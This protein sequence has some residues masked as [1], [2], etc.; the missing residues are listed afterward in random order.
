[1]EEL[2]IFDIG[3][4][5]VITE[6]EKKKEE[7][8]KNSIAARAKAA[9]TP[10][11]KK[12]V[13]PI[14]VQ[15]DWTIHFATESFR[16]EDFVDEIP[17][18]G[19]TLEEVR[20]GI[21]RHF[22]QFSAART[23]WDV[24]KDN[25]RLF[26]DAFAGSKGAVS[27]EGRFTPSFFISA[28]E[29]FESNKIYR[30]ILSGDGNVLSV[31]QS[32]YG[33]MIAPTIKVSDKMVEKALDDLGFPSLEACPV[34]PA[35]FEWILP[36]IPNKFLRQIVG[37]FRSFITEEHEYEVAVKI[38]FD[39]EKEKYVLDVPEQIV[40][41]VYISMINTPEYTGQNASR[42]LP[43]MEVHSHNVM[44]AFF[45]DTDDADEQGNSTTFGVYGVLGRLNLKEYEMVFRAKMRDDEIRIQPEQLFE[46]DVERDDYSYPKHWKTKVTT[47]EGFYL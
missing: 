33:T 6:E 5:D 40:T 14:Y 36:K 15:G 12:K 1:M 30:Y 26:P 46:L 21:E 29:A 17:E 11:E 37:F 4:E 34:T 31:H 16:V 9:A 2:S 19:V 41:P 43:V 18:Q 42:Y 38:Y 20:E 35:S 24:D 22:P 47:K 39:M 27:K 23:K 28:E 45:S 3:I 7:A 44:R 32:G 25:K 13:E 8:Q 10:K